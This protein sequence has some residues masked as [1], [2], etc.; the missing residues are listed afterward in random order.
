MTTLVPAK[1]YIFF[2][3]QTPYTFTLTDIDNNFYG[4]IG[5]VSSYS[6]K[7]NYSDTF[8]KQYNLTMTTSPFSVLTFLLNINGDVASV[9]GPSQTILLLG[10]TVPSKNT[11]SIFPPT[12][13]SVGDPFLGFTQIVPLANGVHPIY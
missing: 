7:L 6:L 5:A 2:Y 12:V 1:T 8:Q 13:S 9:T 4:T 10:L 11:I 3:N